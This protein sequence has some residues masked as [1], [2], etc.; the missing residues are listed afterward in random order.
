MTKKIMSDQTPINTRAAWRPFLKPV[1]RLVVAAQLALALQP[2]SALALEKGQVPYNPVAQA[3]MTRLAQLDQT[4]QR[5]KAA[6]GRSAVDVSGEQLREARELVAQLKAAGTPGKAEKHRRLRDLT[7]AS[8]SG[9]ADVRAELAQTRAMLRSKG[10]PAEILARHDAAVARFEQRAGQFARAAAVA[11]DAERVRQ[12]DAF[13][14]QDPAKRRMT[15]LDPKKLPWSTPKPNTRAPAE[16]RTAWFQNLYGDQKFR[17]A[18]AGGGSIGPLQFNVAPDPGQAPTA[19][20]LA[21]TDEVQITPAIRAKAL[22]LGNNPV[23]IFNWVHNNIEW[24]PTAGAIQSAQDTLD[25]LRGNA[26]DTASLLIALLRAANVP[27]RYRWGTIDVPT[28]QAQNWVGGATRPEAVL[29]ILNQGGIAARGMSGAARFAAIRMEHVWVDAYVNWNPGRG[30]R[31][32]TAN[33]HPNPNAQLNAWVPLDPSYKQYGY[34]AAMDLQQN[35]P[36]DP[37]A[38]LTAAQ[39]GATVN[40]AEGWVQNLNQAAVQ[41]QLADYQN[42]LQ[43]YIASTPTAANS[44]VGDVVGKKIIP[45]QLQPLLAGTLSNPVVLQGSQAAAIPSAL[46]HKFTYRIYASPTDQEDDSPM[47]AYTEKTSKLVGKRLTL[48]YAPASQADADLIASYLPKPHADG[49]PTQPSE[50]PTSLPGY[51]IRL[52]P[53]I[54]LDGQVVAQSATSVQ[55]GTDLYSTGGFTQLYDATQWD[56]TSEESNV[57]GNS[58]AIGISAG[59][60][61]APQLDRLRQRLQAADTQLQ[62]LTSSP[63]SNA[64]AGLSGEQVTG[65]LL[66]ATLWSW[67]ASSENHSR[68][69]RNPAGMV[70]NPGLSYGLFH[71][72]ANPIESWGVIRKVT[73][74]GFNMDVGH[75]RNLTW[76]KDNDSEKWVRY[77]KLRG[78]HMS[79]LEAAVPERF[80]NDPGQ[81]NL[82]DATTPNPSL[83]ACP[84]GIS[85]LKAIGI[86]AQ[87]G[88]KIFTITQQVYANN[89]NIVSSHL[90]AHSANS[91]DRVEQALAAGYEVTIH[92]APIAQNG[93]SGA[94]FILTDPTTGAGAYLIDGGSNGAFLA[95]LL[96]VVGMFLLINAIGPVILA[97]LL[98]SLAIH[99]AIVALSELIA[100]GDLQASDVFLGAAGALS[101]IRAL[102]MVLTALGVAVVVPAGLVMG[103]ILLTLAI[104]GFIRMGN[105]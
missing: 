27:A 8:Q 65:D 95:A 59:G 35:V 103:L 67:F 48:T 101:L 89:P 83:P 77:N 55:M 44:T 34:G 40:T 31:N 91:K 75:V 23:D 29:Q 9:V 68:L 5:A 87:A 11:D 36:L 62:A 93:W 105:R 60:I 86:A 7:D 21:E 15:P 18:Q 26:T 58:T 16:S 81:C 43:A 52:K 80:F 70:E 38:L 45:H 12:L 102:A 96:G 46:Q 25:K 92:E 54:N 57:A 76:A 17:L 33:Q 82:Q 2:L 63:A 72:L 73:F 88:Q 99:I 6:T 98:I 20:D 22:E 42:R 71:A 1:A 53:Q 13:F 78:Q 84:Q 39:Q 97:A 61:S 41:N 79:G 10:T 3:Q 37:N 100:M 66:A 47:L 30:S 51:L 85:A 94:G 69:T 32:A 49:S 24:V 90:W 56:L 4:I 14:A 104:L 28:P 74:P 64:A 19:A 50:L